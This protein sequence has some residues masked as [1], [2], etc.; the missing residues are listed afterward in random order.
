MSVLKGAVIF[1]S[2]VGVGGV[3][4]Y[5]Y[6]KKKYDDREEDLRELKEHYNKKILDDAEIEKMDRIIESNQYVSYDKMTTEVPKETIKETAEESKM[7]NRPRENNPKE[8]FI[9]DENEYSE[10]ELY[11]DKVELDYFV[12]DEAL[13]DE[14]DELIDIN[15]SIGFDILDDFIKDENEDVIYV[16]NPVLNTDYMVNKRF[17]KYSDIV[18][19]GGDDNDE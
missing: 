1:L 8:A 10:K 12:E 2:G 19:L 5:L 6:F 14:G 13:L 9:I 3:A 7:A 4:S 15:T 16:R 17:G 11:F 18:G